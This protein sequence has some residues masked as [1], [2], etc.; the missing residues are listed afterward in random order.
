MVKFVPKGVV[1]E[2]QWDSSLSSLRSSCVQ[3]IL[4]DAVN[5]F[6]QVR[7]PDVFKILMDMRDKLDEKFEI[8]NPLHPDHSS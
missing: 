3:N 2:C 4:S 7:N 6:S 5:L 8:H 1:N